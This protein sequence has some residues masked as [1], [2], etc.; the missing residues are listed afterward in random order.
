VFEVAGLNAALE[1]EAVHELE[2]THDRQPVPPPPFAEH[3]PPP[4]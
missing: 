3:G 1:A 2:H 4:R